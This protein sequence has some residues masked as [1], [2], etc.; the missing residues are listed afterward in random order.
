[1]KEITI[2]ESRYH[3][4]L[5][6]MVA[7]AWFNPFYANTI[8]SLDRSV[9]KATESL[10]LL[11]D[12][13]LLSKSASSSKI[14]LISGTFD[15]ASE[16]LSEISHYLTIATVGLLAN[17][18]LVRITHYKL[19][20]LVMLV[21]WVFT[22][23]GRYKEQAHR[24]LVMFLFFNPGMSIY[25]MVLVEFT[26]KI[27]LNEKTSLNAQVQCIYDDYAKKEELRKKKVAERRQAQLNKDKTKGK[28]H[29]SLLQK[30]EDAAINKIGGAEESISKDFTMT[31]KS[32][33]LA[34]KNL[35]PL[36]LEHFTITLFVNVLIPVGHLLI[37]Y[38]LL[39]RVFK[40]NE[41]EIVSEADTIEKEGEHVVDH[42]IVR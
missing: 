29:L 4:G 32:I 30:T 36:V 22:F 38:L 34:V 8:E 17:D 7:L 3:I 5:L 26:E 25:T 13:Y 1:M 41:D 9:E 10:V 21:L 23:Y 42:S 40:V 19:V 33:K 31:V 28:N 18:L 27:N 24:L 15:G 39:M 11:E 16:A 2:L 35:K 20:V 12:L 37:S 14:P 6:V